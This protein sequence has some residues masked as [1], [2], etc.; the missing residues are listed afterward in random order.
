M[1]AQVSKEKEKKR[2]PKTFR[3]HAHR[4]VGMES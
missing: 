4:T 2:N 3:R 1:N